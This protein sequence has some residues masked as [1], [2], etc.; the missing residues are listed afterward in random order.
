MIHYYRVLE[1]FVWHWS[2]EFKAKQNSAFMLRSFVHTHTINVQF[3]ASFKN[4]IQRQ[5]R[6]DIKGWRVF[7]SCF[8]SCM[9]KKG[10]IETVISLLTNSMREGV[11][12]ILRYVS[13]YLIII[14]KLYYIWNC[15]YFPAL[16]LKIKSSHICGCKRQTKIVVCDWKFSM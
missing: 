4:I 12:K 8:Q 11:T 7:F 3:G 14:F 6:Y 10:Q 5:V 9:W 1:Q 16:H 2:I 15:I 13:Q